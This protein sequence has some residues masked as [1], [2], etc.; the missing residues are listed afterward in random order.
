[1]RVSTAASGPWLIFVY[2]VTGTPSAQRDLESRI[3]IGFPDSN[4]AK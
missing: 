3:T 2:S 1:L 4:P